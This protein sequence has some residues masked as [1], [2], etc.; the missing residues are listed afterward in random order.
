MKEVNLTMVNDGEKCVII[1]SNPSNPN[2]LND[3]IAEVFNI[4]NDDSETLCDFLDNNIIVDIAHDVPVELLDFGDCWES[5]NNYV[6][7]IT[8]K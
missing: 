8:M 1:A 4:E 5:R 6:Y 7:C 3:A 2:T